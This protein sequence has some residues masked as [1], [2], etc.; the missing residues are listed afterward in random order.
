MI[1]ALA[2]MLVCVV[3]SSMIVSTA[4]S[5]VNRNEKRVTQQQEYLAV[6][7]AAGLIAEELK[8]AGTY[9]GY[10]IMHE[11]LCQS[12]YRPNLA[13]ETVTIDA[14]SYYGYPLEEEIVPG[15]SH[16]LLLQVGDSEPNIQEFFCPITREITVTT[17]D[18]DSF[19]SLLKA[20]CEYVVTNT[21]SYEKEFTMYVDGEDKRLPKVQCKFVMDTE[22]GIQVQVSVKDGKSDYTM[23]VKQQAVV[24]REEAEAVATTVCEEG[25]H[26]ILVGTEIIEKKLTR[27]NP[28]VNLEISWPD[29]QIIK[30]VQ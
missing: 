19:S 23:I 17:E 12:C 29:A 3:V 16:F 5:G 14:V 6:S 26:Q 15:A 10:M 9:K 27:E 7:S 4:A 30:G 24:N 18:T 22:F 21:A 13:L 28:C 20:A 1:F 2:L 25:V 11:P 8:S